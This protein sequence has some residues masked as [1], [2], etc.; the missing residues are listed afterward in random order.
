MVTQ[1]AG[2]TGQVPTVAFPNA[3]SARANPTRRVARG[4]E[5]GDGGD[6]LTDQRLQPRARRGSVLAML[7][8]VAIVGVLEG[9]SV[10]GTVA[11]EGGHRRGRRAGRERADLQRRAEQ[12]RRLLGVQQLQRVER[13]RG[14]R[15]ES[16]ACP[17]TIP[18]APAPWASAR[19]ARR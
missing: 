10:G 4:A 2:F 8:V 3:S 17:R 19:A 7:G 6:G 15:A 16:R 14:R 1:V 9:D 12:R 13:R 5:G 11:G 18:R